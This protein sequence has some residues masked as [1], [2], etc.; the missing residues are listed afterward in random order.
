MRLQEKAVHT[1]VEKE[2]LM[3]CTTQDLSSRKRGKHRQ[4]FFIVH[5]NN[6][7]NNNK[8]NNK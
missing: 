1:V 8:N 4:S 7:N 6:N 2:I 5:N 3:Q